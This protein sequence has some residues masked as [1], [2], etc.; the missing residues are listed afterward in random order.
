[1]GCRLCIS[2]FQL[3]HSPSLV[4]CN[5]C[6]LVLLIDIV[7]RLPPLVRMHSISDFPTPPPPVYN[8]IVQ[9]NAY[10]NRLD[11]CFWHHAPYYK[12]FIISPTAAI[13]TTVITPAT[14]YICFTS[15]ISSFSKSD[16]VA[17][18]FELATSATALSTSSLVTSGIRFNIQS[19]NDR[20]VPYQYS[21]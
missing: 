5:V 3:S 15:L 11:T 10:A 4:Y 7:F 9:Y 19:L 2:C 14:I 8:D 21:R 17:T 12:N 13:F 20:P 16:L 1:M 6:F 18:S